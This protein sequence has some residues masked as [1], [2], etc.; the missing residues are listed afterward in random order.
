MYIVD[1]LVVGP[2][3]NSAIYFEDY[4]RLLKK[5]EER[6]IKIESKNVSTY[7]KT[8]W[9]VC[10]KS[11]I[12]KCSG[13]VFSSCLKYDEKW[14]GIVCIY[15]IIVNRDRMMKWWENREKEI[16]G[17]SADKCF[18]WCTR[19]LIL[20]PSH[21]ISIFAHTGSE[22]KRKNRMYVYKKKDSRLIIADWISW[23]K[24]KRTSY[25]LSR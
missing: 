9:K 6:R 2:K 13:S 20:S 23:G 18:H 22:P 1:V 16:G 14:V 15:N 3:L 24:R 11:W 8:P 12:S 4:W 7:E 5:R 21:F 10:A 19:S 25:D 17:V